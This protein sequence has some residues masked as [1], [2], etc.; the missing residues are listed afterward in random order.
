MASYLPPQ[1]PSNGT[2]HYDILGV[3]LNATDE[4]IK[5]AY[6]AKAR[7]HHPDKTLNATSEEM[8]KR[9]NKAKSILTDEVRRLEYNE[10]LLDDENSS[11]VEAE[12]ALP[13]GK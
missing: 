3:G 9:I 1:V 11:L 8:M 13:L 7:E 2:N 12:F 10:E 5:R 6:Y 4:D